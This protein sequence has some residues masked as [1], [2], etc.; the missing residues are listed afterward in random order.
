VAD[1]VSSNVFD[2]MFGYSP[3]SFGNSFG[4]ADTSS[5]GGGASSR[6]PYAWAQRLR[7]I[8]DED[9]LAELSMMGYTDG[10]GGRRSA[11][12]FS[13]ANGTGGGSHRCCA[14]APCC[15]QPRPSE[16]ATSVERAAERA[17]DPWSTQS[18]KSLPAQPRLIVEPN[19]CVNTSQHA[20]PSLH[21]R[22]GAAPVTPPPFAPPPFMHS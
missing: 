10:V 6:D 2:S 1:G 22:G 11:D 18:E 17:E 20:A 5:P 19:E 3:A 21:P 9:V 13:F 4:A 8:P 16:G 7:D 12:K 14:C 15:K